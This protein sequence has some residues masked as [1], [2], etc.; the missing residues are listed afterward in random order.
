MSPLLRATPNCWIC[1]RPAELESC[2]ID[3]HGQPMHEDCYIAKLALD[4]ETRSNSG[5]MGRVRHSWREA[6]LSVLDES[7]PDKLPGRIENAITALE[8]R[9]AEWGCDPGTPAEL[10][11]I[12][13][14]L[15][16]LGRLMNE[17][18]V[19]CWDAPPLREAREIS[20]ATRHN[21]ANE[22][23]HVQHLFVVLRT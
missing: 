13:K 11:T 6:F 18:R 1:G 4:R 7:D 3:E 15:S 14:A 21:L 23:K 8:R 9:Y 5:H 2:K 20:D 19:T 12:Q 17:E 22:L 16:A 10:N